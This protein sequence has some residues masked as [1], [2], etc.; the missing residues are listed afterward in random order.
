[1]LAWL[2]CTVSE[3]SQRVDMRNVATRGDDGLCGETKI[4][5]VSGL[6]PAHLVVSLPR[7]SLV[8]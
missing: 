8:V 4:V 5:R 3:R 7:K 2:A 1:M 6:G